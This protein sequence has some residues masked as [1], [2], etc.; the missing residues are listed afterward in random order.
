MTGDLP[1]FLNAITLADAARAGGFAALGLGAGLAYFRALAA[2]VTQTLEAGPRARP[3]AL[4]VARVVLAGI[5][6][7]A[8][9]TQGAV[10]LLAAFAGFLAARRIARRWTP[11]LE[12][13]P[14]QCT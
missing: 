1:S 13:A 9:S 3:V 10:A 11:A 12:G 7:W 8:V 6:F 2:A 4:H 14:G 5:F